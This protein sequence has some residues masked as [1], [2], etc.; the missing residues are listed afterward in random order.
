MVLL[1]EICQMFDPTQLSKSTQEKILKLIQDELIA[2]DAVIKEEKT[3]KVDPGLIILGY[4]GVGKSSLSKVHYHDYIDLESSWFKDKSGDIWWETYCTV[5]EN[6]SKNGHVVFMS[7]H[8]EVRNWLHEHTK[9][10]VAVVYPSVKL[11]DQWLEK[12]SIRWEVSGNEKDLRAFERAE[13]HYESDILELAGS[14]FEC[15]ELDDMNYE[16]GTLVHQ[17][18]IE[19]GIFGANGR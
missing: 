7:C 2:I 12:L 14:G 10:H 5:A 1:D 9:E 18:R 3:G 17:L 15:V 8:S 11:K 19:Q 16:L 13:K 4:P 6:L